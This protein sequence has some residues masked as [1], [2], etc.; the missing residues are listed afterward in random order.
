VTSS[1]GG[2]TKCPHS[3]HHNATY[4]MT[5]DGNFY[6]AAMTDLTARDPAIYRMMGGAK[7][8]RTA[9]YNSRWLNGR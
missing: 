2:V 5:S 8:L 6:T 4:I 7:H 3:P 9:Q 1:V